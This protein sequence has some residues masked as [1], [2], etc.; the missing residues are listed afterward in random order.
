M[1]FWIKLVVGFVVTCIYPSGSS[2]KSNNITISIQTYNITTKVCNVVVL[3]K[4]DP[5]TSHENV[6]ARRIRYRLSP[7]FHPTITV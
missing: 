6:H 7:V 5:L 2:Y 4:I 1:Q 3:F